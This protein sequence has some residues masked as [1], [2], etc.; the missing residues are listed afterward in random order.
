MEESGVIEKVTEPTDWVN[1]LVVVEKPNGKLRV[2]IDPKEL[3]KAI[4]RPHYPMPTLEDVLSKMSGAKYFSK[5]DARSGYW[6]LRLSEDSSYL[7][8]FNT[9][10]GRYRFQRL[11]FGIICAQDVFQRKMDET[12]E[13]ISGVTP[14]VDDIIVYGKTLEEHDANLKATLER[15]TQKKLKLNPDK[16][17][18]GTQQVEYF[19]HLITA[20]GLK[21]DP[22][23][24]LAIQNMP[25]PADKKELHTMLGM[26]TY[27]AKFA[28]QMSE[29]TKPMRDLLKE[30][31]EFIWDK[32][33][34]TALQK[35]KD[36]ITSQPLLA[37]FD[38]KKEVKLE[39]D[40]SKF[41]LGAAIFQ[42]DK[43]VAFASKSLTPTEQNYAQ[44]E[45][46]LYAI[47]FGCHRFHQYLYGREITVFSDHKPLE[48]ITKKPLAAAPPRLQ[49]MLLQL[50]NYRLNIVHTPGK[51]I[52]VAD[53][54]S[55]KFLP[56]EP[57]DDAVNILFFLL[58]L[59]FYSYKYTIVN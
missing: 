8:T 22:N 41:G 44:I 48:S 47:L 32:Q 46:E 53:T 3:N 15:A 19:G 12:F 11:P 35:I 26:I 40:A 1:S 16:L 38:P 9:P 33:Q 20:E 55:R 39:V 25:P 18:V 5:L 52:P 37:F 36:T 43:P 51:N 56:A 30:D 27:L 24:V 45:K 6:Q 29:I 21:P 23:K 34:Q 42:D 31:A 59:L 49:R 57:Q 7:T 2:C 13:G 10:F 28:P 4:K 54:L 58:L 14:L 50:Q 17:N